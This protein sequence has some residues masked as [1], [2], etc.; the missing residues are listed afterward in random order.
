MEWPDKITEKQIAFVIAFVGE[1]KGNATKAAKVA[2]YSDAS[3]GRELR[4]KT[5]VIEAIELYRRHLIDSGQ[6]LVI[7]P[8]RVHQEW[9]DILED[10]ETTRHE[11]I[12]LLR[13]AARASGMFT[14][15]VNIH[16]DRHPMRRLVLIER[17]KWDP[18]TEA[19]E[20]YLKR[21][22]NSINEGREK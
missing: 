17:N 2:G 10:I 18:E 11:K 22:M 4:T 9:L 3:Y 20:E 16:D 19:A 5:H 1:A 7:D 6:Y 14:E 12:Q 13:D 15:N 21:R 8:I